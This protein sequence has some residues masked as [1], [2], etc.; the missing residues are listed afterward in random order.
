[1]GT[2]QSK[3]I[4][5]QDII[6]SINQE[7]LY[8][9]LN[10]TKQT[11]KAMLNMKNKL[12]LT[13][14]RARVKCLNV[15]QKIN[16]VLDQNVWMDIINDMNIVSS[17]QDQLK[18]NLD[19]LI[20]SKKTGL[21]NFIS[22]DKLTESISSLKDT[23]NRIVNSTVTNS[24]LSEIVSN[25]S[26]INEQNIILKDFVSEECVDLSQDIQVQLVVDQIVNNISRSIMRS[27]V[28]KD[29]N[30]TIAQEV[31]TVEKADPISS[32]ISGV[33]TTY[34]IIGIIVA[35]LFI[36]IAV[37]IYKWAKPQ[38]KVDLVTGIAR[39]SATMFGSRRNGMLRMKYQ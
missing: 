12:N 10:E 2:G 19:T 23:V 34:I 30:S 11:Q 7:E 25:V 15:G 9:I 35:I 29:L 4:T 16:A 32:L 3:T 22:G 20:D 27:S 26:T 1:M 24:T 13:M 39:N 8:E 5:R 33:S 21:A 14:I 18:S 6:T 31:K 17:L 37:L 36:V 38:S 28:I